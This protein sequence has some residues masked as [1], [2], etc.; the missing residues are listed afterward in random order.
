[1][2]ELSALPRQ[3][4]RSLRDAK[5]R[6][7]DEFVVPRPTLSLS[8]FLPSRLDIP[9]ETLWIDSSSGTA[10]TND[11]ADTAPLGPSERRRAIERGSKFFR[12]PREATDEDVAEW[13]RLAECDW[14][15]VYHESAP[16]RDLDVADV[17]Y[18]LERCSSAALAQFVWEDLLVNLV[19][20]SLHAPTDDEDSEESAGRPT[21]P[22]LQQVRELLAM[23]IRHPSLAGMP[24]KR[25]RAS[26]RAMNLRRIDEVAGTQLELEIVS[27]FQRQRQRQQHPD[28]PNAVS[29]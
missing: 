16:H 27:H 23:L 13:R 17:C 3:A 1:M 26:V 21:E 6:V 14:R 29:S 5:V 24:P 2:V 12:C 8:D 28:P 9:L 15:Q 4:P 18:G 20:Q 22:P 7:E 25:F 19:E 10:Y 11:S